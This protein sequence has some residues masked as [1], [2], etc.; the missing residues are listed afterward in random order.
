MV[1]Q[2]LAGCLGVEASVLLQAAVHWWHHPLQTLDSITH[3]P[4]LTLTLTLALQ[5]R[6]R[7]RQTG[8]Q[9]ALRYRG[10]ESEI[11]RNR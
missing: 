1:M 11:E 3:V 5:T 9:A 6:H 10:T 7:L 8:R 2:V 4:R